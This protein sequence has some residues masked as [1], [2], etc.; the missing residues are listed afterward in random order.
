MQ[1]TAPTSSCVLPPWATSPPL[2]APRGWVGSG[3]GWRRGSRGQPDLHT[4]LDLGAPRG[5]PVTAVFPGRVIAAAPSGSPGFSRYGNT[6]VLVHPTEGFEGV[7]PIYSLYAHLESIAPGVLQGVSVQ[8][9]RLLGG[10]GDTQGTPEDPNLR[11]TSPHL[12][13]EFLSRWPPR[14]RDVDRFDASAVL[15]QAGLE[16]EP[17][18]ALRVIPGG[19][20][21]AGASCLARA[22]LPTP[23]PASSNGAIWLLLA[24]LLGGGDLF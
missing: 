2:A 16:A 19:R 12:H 5:W 9:G 7:R 3:Y 20:A 15:E 6:V 13:L 11:T 10:V 17:H 18:T 8:A 4:G 1:L 21:A 14:A 24:L 23:A 22:N